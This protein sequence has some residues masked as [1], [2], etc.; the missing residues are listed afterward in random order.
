MNYKLYTTV[1]ISNTGQYRP[2][3][4]KEQLRWKEQNFQTVLQTLGLRSNIIYNTKPEMIEVCG[5]VVG[6]KT[7]DIIRVW[8]FDWTTEREFLYEH[9][10]DPVCFLKDDFHL[11]PYIDGLDELMEQKYRVFN[12]KEEKPNI[13]FYQKS[14]K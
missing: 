10:G 9:E 13:I 8:R 14:N 12:S 7:K 4:G 11:V 1:D 2:E 6:F 5:E 3:V